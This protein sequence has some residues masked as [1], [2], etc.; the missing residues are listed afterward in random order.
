MEPLHAAVDLSFDTWLAGCDYPGHRKSELR[1]VY[2]KLST[3]GWDAVA[4]RRGKRV[5]DAFKCK[6]F[7]KV[8]TYMD[9][10]Y[11]RSI[12]S[13]C[14]AFKVYT[15]P[16]FAAIERALFSRKE[17]IK[18]VPVKDRP[19]YIFENLSGM[20]KYHVTDYT[21]FEGSFVPTLM[22]ECEMRLY[23]YMLRNFPKE[24]GIIEAAL[25]GWNQCR[26]R[27]YSV[28][29]RGTR[30]SG[31]MCTSLGNGF[32]NLMLS[33]F[34]VSRV[35]G[36]IKVVVEG[37]DSIVGTDVDIDVAEIAKLGFIMKKVSVPSLHLTSFCGLML[38]REL[39]AMVDPVKV[40]LN[41]GWS[42]SPLALSSSKNYKPLLR[43][44]AMSLVYE[45]PRCPIVTAL[46]LKWLEMTE[47]AE[48]RFGDDWYHKHVFKEA[49][50]NGQ[51]VAEQ[52]RLGV[53]DEIREDFASVFG[54][55]REVQLAIESE[56]ALGGFHFGPQTEWLLSSS[57][58][59]LQYYD[60]YV[61]RFKGSEWVQSVEAHLPDYTLAG[62]RWK[63]PELRG[64]AV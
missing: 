29:L 64:A 14:D 28:K 37:D 31:D 7:T 34:F 41:F 19:Q 21:S 32:T 8:E 20:P 5:P 26:F 43:A 55:S 16:L 46:G 62:G 44:K 11:A 47:G 17:F 40:L 10:K 49:Q 9:F 36:H 24:Y 56:I 2:E 61:D 23:R 52:V 6:S 13:R 1:R 25:T 58:A 50:S 63:I 48:A 12:N 59:P 18:H 27:D 15:G 30:M 38:S 60:L 39:T 4:V 45:Y 42:H 57:V 3:E 35:G 51:W 53:S 54:V 22:L 33:S